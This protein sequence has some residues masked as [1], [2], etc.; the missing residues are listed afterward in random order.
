MNKTLC[1]PR[2]N[3]E[4]KGNKMPIALSNYEEILPRIDHWRKEAEDLTRQIESITKS[5]KSALVLDRWYR[6]SE[7]SGDVCAR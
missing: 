3:R 7:E 5:I 6:L 1:T 2:F 4:I